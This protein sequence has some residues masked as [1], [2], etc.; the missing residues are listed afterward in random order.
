M[1]STENGKCLAS[2]SQLHSM[3]KSV[4]G[5]QIQQPDYKLAS[6]RRELWEDLCKSLVSRVSVRLG[7]VSVVTT[8]GEENTSL[9]AN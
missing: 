3:I 1:L 7:D 6:G 2:N 9:V 5:C 8:S 4:R